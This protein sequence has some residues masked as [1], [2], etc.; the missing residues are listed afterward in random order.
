MGEGKDTFVGGT[1]N[2]FHDC[3]PVEDLRF[4]NGAE[5][6]EEG[7]G[8]FGLGFEFVEEAFCCGW[9]GGGAG[10]RGHFCGA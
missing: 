1:G 10:G 4:G 7:G 3:F 8:V 9:W 5:E 2:A 6:E